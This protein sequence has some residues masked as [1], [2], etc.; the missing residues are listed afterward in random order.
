MK[1]V[2]IIHYTFAVA[3]LFTWYRAD[4]PTIS[5]YELKLYHLNDWPDCVALT[6]HFTIHNSKGFMFTMHKGSQ[7]NLNN[8]N[9]IEI[10]CVCVWMLRW[11]RNVS[12]HINFIGWMDRAKRGFVS[13]VNVFP[14]FLYFH[15]QQ[16]NRDFAHRHHYTQFKLNTN[17]TSYIVMQNFLFWSR[18]VLMLLDASDVEIGPIVYATFWIN[19]KLTSTYYVDK[20]WREYSVWKLKWFFDSR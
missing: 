12:D 13:C 8:Q 15:V 16:Q 19:I 2:H 14:L 1:A 17:R 6:M 18:L 5:L 4:G 11:P 9:Y 20:L 3:I 7:L 10:M